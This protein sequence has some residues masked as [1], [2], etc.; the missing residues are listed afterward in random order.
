[1][2]ITKDMAASTSV[3]MKV[4]NEFESAYNLYDKDKFLDF[5]TTAWVLKEVDVE[6]VEK[7][8]LRTKVK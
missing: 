5:V 4:R 6:L 7:E 2:P 8:F 1:M 3:W